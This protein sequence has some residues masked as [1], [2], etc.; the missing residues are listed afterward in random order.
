MSPTDLRAQPGT[1]APHVWLDRGEQRIST[2]DLFGRGFV[3]LT[4]A[5]GS[6]WLEAAAA[7]ASLDVAA[8]AIGAAGEL[9]DPAR[10]WATTYGIEPGGAV[11]VR[12]D[13]FVAWRAVGPAVDPLAELTAAVSR[14]L[15]RQQ[16]ATLAR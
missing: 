13:G 4:D 12:P 11:L 15:G 7:I 5:I 2:I 9:N 8:F 1:R 6:S 3:L 14:I 10:D 16:L